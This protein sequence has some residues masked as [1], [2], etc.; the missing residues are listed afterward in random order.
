ME[1]TPDP[2]VSN[3]RGAAEADSSPAGLWASPRPTFTWTAIG[4]LFLALAGGGVWMINEK[5]EQDIELASAAFQHD[6][7]AR[8]EEATAVV[9]GKL[10]LIHQ[11]L[12]TMGL[13]PSVQSIDR[14]GENLDAD[15]NKTIQQ[16]YDS[17]AKDVELSEVY[18]VPA[19]FDPD[20]IDPDTGEPEEPI[21]MFDGLI[22]DGVIEEEEDEEIEIEEYRA[23]A[24]QMAWLGKHYPVAA[25][26]DAGARPMIST[27]EM[28]I[29]DNTVFSRTRDEADRKGVVLSVP[30]YGLDGELR[31][32]ISGIIRTGAL[33]SYLPQ[34]DFALTNTA[35]GLTVLPKKP[36]VE[37]TSLTYVKKGV[38]D[39]DLPYSAA[40]ELS[41]ADPQGRWVA[42][43]GRS[44]SAFRDSPQVVSIRNFEMTA[45]II[46][47]LLL[48]VLLAVVLVMRSSARL[49]GAR[50]A[51]LREIAEEMSK[52][53]RAVA[54]RESRALRLAAQLEAN[55]KSLRATLAD[56]T[57]AKNAAEAASIAKS[58][59]LANMSHEIRTPLNGVLGIAQVLASDGLEAAHAEKVDLILD[60]GKSLL[61]LLNDVLDLSKIEAGKLEISPA[62]WDVGATVA[63]AVR[64]FRDQAE[65][66]GLTLD[67]V[68]GGDL[69]RMQFDAARVRQ[70][71]SNLVSNAIKFTDSGSVKI[72][73]SAKRSEDGGY[74]VLV[75]VRDTG[76]GMSQEVIDRLFSAFTQA[77]GSTTRRFGGTGLGLAISRL[78][79]RRMGGDILVKS[80]EGRGSVFGFF[81]QASEASAEELAPIEAMLPAASVSSDPLRGA[82]VLLADDNALNRKIIRLML[83]P[84]GCEIVEA[85]NGQLTLDLLATQSFDIVLLD[86]HMPVMDGLEAIRRI[87]TCSESWR[88]VPVIALTADAMA[89]DR[90]KYLAM[91]M[92]AYLS[93][94]VDKQALVST[95]SELLG[96]PRQRLLLTGT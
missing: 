45:W 21:M 35:H 28:T 86:A 31:G 33:A 95:M 22:T 12:N 6:V 87:R 14:H 46:L 61:I 43:V 38:A 76:I 92:S 93:K 29:C 1:T 32:T 23:L 82:I 70:C 58:Q 7:S 62:P 55:Q 8:A 10:R 72:S 37:R 73:L 42:W 18:I 39:P 66:K 59:F 60:A 24:Q 13:L 27:P 71:V 91:G 41:Q 89:G 9:D 80:R 69:P 20:R 3:A 65:Q 77:D 88:D 79:A 48:A 49:Q 53:Q 54:E 19:S 57:L 47:G 11:S 5:V 83:S 30:F 78:L 50:Q 25:S 40:M 4:V 94:P 26:V 63:A 44:S 15:A 96:A 34:T 68:S 64:L 52:A 51:H 17:L 81:F 36:G 75:Q 16:L 85:E 56:L 90:E 84:C 67:L 74:R 2:S